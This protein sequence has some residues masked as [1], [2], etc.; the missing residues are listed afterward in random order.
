MKAHQA[1]SWSFEDEGDDDDED[2]MVPPPDTPS[3]LS[4]GHQSSIGDSRMDEEEDDKDIDPLD[5][6]MTSLE[7]DG[8][9]VPQAEMYGA[10]GAGDETKKGNGFDPLGSTTITAE[11]LLGGAASK[12]AKAGWESD[13]DMEDDNEEEE[14]ELDE[15]KLEQDRLAF[16]A[17]LRGDTPKVPE[18]DVKPEI[19]TEVSFW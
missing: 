15:E 14:E 16:L 12:S 9:K 6:F 7:S 8:A 18:A 13:T 3:A 1:K 10:F 19:K 17:A 5:A 11:E 4:L 2:D